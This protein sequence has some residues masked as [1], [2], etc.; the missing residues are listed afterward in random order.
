MKLV[1]SYHN[2]LITKV[3]AVWNKKQSEN[4][5]EIYNL[6][7]IDGSKKF[8]EITSR[9]KFLSGLFEEEGNIKNQAKKFLKR[10]NYCLSVCFKKIRINKTR[11]NKELEELFTRRRILRNKKDDN[12]FQ[13]L[14][15]VK[16]K[17]AENVH[18][19]MQT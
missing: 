13:C 19:I 9:R 11:K 2:S 12:S 14:K 1:V 6:K 16:N 3:K 4:R 10:L 8:K 18:L 17:L 5:T 15:K 7:D